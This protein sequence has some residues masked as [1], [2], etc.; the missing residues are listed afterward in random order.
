MLPCA[1][2]DV[3]RCLSRGAGVWG[4][5][6]FA[7]GAMKTRWRFRDFDTPRVQDLEASPNPHLTEP[8]LRN[9]A[10]TRRSKPQ[11][12]PAGH[13]LSACASPFLPSLLHS[14]L[15][16]KHLSVSLCPHITLLI[17]HSPP[18]PL[19]VYLPPFLPGLCLSLCL[20]VKCSLNHKLGTQWLPHI[21][22]VGAHTQWPPMN[23]LCS[24][25]QAGGSGT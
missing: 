15:F 7:K 22:I 2:S 25:S 23:P 9:S 5:T 17:S 6:L 12:R 20:S 14:P 21:L 10:G 13:L 19:P 1:A 24:E 3:S 16:L 11:A 8:T 4:R 18:P